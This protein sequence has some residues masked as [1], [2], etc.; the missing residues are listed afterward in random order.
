MATS[1][2]W[3]PFCPATRERHPSAWN[4]CKN[5]GAERPRERLEIKNAIEIL[6]SSPPLSPLYEHRTADSS[7]S[8]SLYQARAMRNQLPSLPAGIDN[9]KPARESGPPK[10]TGIHRA[11]YDARENANI[12]IRGKANT[13]NAGSDPLSIRSLGPR[14]T[15]VF[16][17]TVQV[18][19]IK[20]YYYISP[21]GDRVI[22]ERVFVGK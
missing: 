20:E 11:A 3:S 22:Q 17:W 8:S 10:K 12:R 6:D 2:E 15:A 9:I 13:P 14:T 21:R 16:L 5:C 7:S 1:L 18:V 19:L 4:W